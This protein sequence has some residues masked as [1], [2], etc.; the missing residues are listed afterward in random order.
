MRQL[1]SVLVISFLLMLIIVILPFSPAL[2]VSLTYEFTSGAL[3]GTFTAGFP[4]PSPGFFTAW[5]ITS[6]TGFGTMV[7]DSGNPLQV[8]FAD[9]ELF[10]PDGPVG[11]LG[12]RCCTGTDD[13][14]IGLGLQVHNLIEVNDQFEIVK[15]NVSGNYSFGFLGTNL[16][17]TGSGEWKSVSGPNSLWL[18]LVGLIT[19]VVWRER[20]NLLS[21]QM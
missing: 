10:F 19:L 5:N 3:T 12:L 1:A 9:N 18:L 7:W 4:Q 17:V 21:L 20:Q 16:T 15:H 11:L 8:V 14:P 6:P 13:G 2:A